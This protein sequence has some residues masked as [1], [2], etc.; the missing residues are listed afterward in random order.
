[1]EWRTGAEIVGHELANHVQAVQNK[2]IVL[3]NFEF[4]LRN[5]HY[6]IYHWLKL[7]VY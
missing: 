3:E 2:G 6:P 5:Y 7:V 1:M 4:D